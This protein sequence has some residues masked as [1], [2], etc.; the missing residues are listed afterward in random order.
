MA[1][2]TDTPES[3]LDTHPRRPDRARQ[4]RRV[5]GQHVRKP[6]RQGSGVL[7]PAEVREQTARGRSCI[8]T[9]ARCWRL[10]PVAPQHVRQAVGRGERRRGQ[11][12]PHQQRPALQH[13]SCEGR[14]RDGHD[15]FWFI[16][17]PSTFQKQAIPVTD[18]VQE[19]TKKVEPMTKVAR[20]S[21]FN[22]KT[23]QFYGFPET[24]AP[25]RQYRRSFLEQ[26]GVSSTPGEDLRKEPR[27]SRRSGIRS[28][29]ECRTRSTRTCS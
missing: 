2:V 20:K 7:R 22:P 21:T 25:T 27:S 23:K 11:G 10:R 6:V 18:L 28:V 14:H 12:R 8:M 16:S 4:R 26:T 15:L 3:R 9:W 24:Y 5:R 1:E 19:V 17:P 29:S 13:G